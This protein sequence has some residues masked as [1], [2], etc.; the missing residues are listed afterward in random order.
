[1]KAKIN[2]DGIDIELDGSPEELA[3][4]IKE[5]ASTEKKVKTKKVEKNK[6]FEEEL[7][8]LKELIDEAKPSPPPY[9]SRR[10]NPIYPGVGNDPFWYDVYKITC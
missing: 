5:L 6:S 4:A 8:K 10:S 7:Q 9:A 1:M 2:I 3:E